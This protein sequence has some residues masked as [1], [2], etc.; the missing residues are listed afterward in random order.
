M[1]SENVSRLIKFPGCFPVLMS[2][3]YMI[4]LDMHLALGVIQHI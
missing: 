3:R 2:K 1:S 4:V